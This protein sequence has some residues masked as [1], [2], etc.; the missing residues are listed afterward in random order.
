MKRFSEGCVMLL[1]MPVWLILMVLHTLGHFLFGRY[2][3][4]E[5]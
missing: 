1:L 5:R 3:D 2:D 4:W